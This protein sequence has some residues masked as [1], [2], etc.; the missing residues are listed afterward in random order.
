MFI[1]ELCSNLNQAM[2]IKYNTYVY[3]LKKQNKNVIILSLGEAYFDIPVFSIDDLPNPAIY[4]YSHSRGNLDLRKKLSE[5]YEHN[6]KVNINVEEEILITAGSKAAIYFTFM[7][8]LNPGDEVLVPEPFWVSYPE[9]IKLCNAIPIN[10]PYY[11]SVYHFEDYIT[12]KTK[13]IVIN[14]PNN[15][16]GYLYTKDELIFLINLAKK[17]NLLILSDEAY[18]EFVDNEEFISIGN[19]DLE[20][21]YSVIFNSISKNHGIS[22]W[23]LGYVIANSELIFNILK[24]NQHVITCAPS[25]LEFYVEK[26]FSDILLFTKPQIKQLMEKRKL[27]SAYM[28]EINLVVLPGTATFYFFVSICPSQ[29]SSEEFC[30]SLLK[31]HHISVVPGIGYGSSCESFI[32]VSIGTAS[33]DEIKYALDIIKNIIIQTSKINKTRK[34]LVVGGG[35]WQ[36]PLI[37]HLKNNGYIVLVADPYDHS[38]GVSHADQHVK[39]DVRDFNTIKELVLTESLELIASDQ[40]DISVNTVALL[41]EYFNL[42]GNKFKVTNLFVNKYEMRMFAKKINI[43][44]PKFAK[45]RN[46]HELKL[47]ISEVGLPIILKPADS[48]SSRGVIKLSHGFDIPSALNFC[49][50]HT[51]LDYILA[52]EFVEGEEVTIEGFSSNFQHKTLAKSLKKHFRTGIASE[53]RYPAD[54]PTNMAQ[55]IDAIN[56]KFVECSGLSFG[57][58]HAEYLINRKTGRVCLVEIACRGGGTL[59]SS[60][61]IQGVSGVNVYAEFLKN[62][63]G[64]CSNVKEFKIHNH[65]AIL[66]FLEFP[67]GKVKKIKGVSEIQKLKGIHTFKL[68]FEIGD[69][70]TKAT[71]DRTRQG[72]YIAFAENNEQIDDIIQKVDQ[73]LEIQFEQKYELSVAME[74]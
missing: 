41:N 19:V 1:S 7:A 43:P 58:T 30:T 46:L 5:F 6:Y 47:F 69:T 29:L 54:I 28:N 72:F 39:A 59:I 64:N 22:G 52:E 21:K 74:S 27:V 3:D 71:D 32:R 18:S 50:M 11:I 42:P 20:K 15:P 73:I 36:I 14:N 62:L 17:Y 4:H 31:D 66:K 2:S 63:Q 23:R 37:S 44:I 45:I 25:I 48:Q 16:S 9:Q 68:L 70:L 65:C 51:S 12:E 49:A 57:I 40:S 8:I 55:Q 13:A 34:A 56:N 60:D 67:E 61:I 33:L 35:L 24:I 26:Y 53:L 38:P 10:V